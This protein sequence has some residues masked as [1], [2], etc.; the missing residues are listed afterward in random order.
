MKKTIVLLALFASLAYAPSVLACSPAPGYP[1]SASDNLAQKDVAFIGTVTSIMR[2]KSVNGDYH[3]TFAVN[4]SLKGSMDGTV[5]VTTRSSS[6]ACG[7]DDAY[8][9]FKTGAVWAMYAVGTESTYSTNS[10]SLNTPY[11]SVKTARAE[12]ETLGIR[13]EETTPTMCTMQYQPVCGKASNGTIKTFGNACTLAAEKAQFL[14]E[15]ECKVA[16]S[17]VPTKNLWIGMRGMDVT[18]LQNFLITKATGA[19]SELLKKVGATGYFGTL[20]KNALA[21]Y[22]AARGVTPAVGYFGPLTRA[23]ILLDTA[24]F[25][26]ATFKGKIS[27]VDTACFADGVCSVTIDGR[28]VVLAAG[29]RINVPPLG[30]LTGVDSIGDLEDEIGSEAEVYA[31]KVQDG[32]YTL[33]GSTSYYVKVI[34]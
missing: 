13:P 10:L 8:S 23:Q 19:A 2:D 9:S 15:G 21:E 26:T 22:Q 28:K 7:Y 20:T 27:A 6:A 14:Y 34:K 32:S 25:E 29:L 33:Y 18:W 24:P 17:T 30:S 12:L 16:V 1:L 3:I 11:P 31:A 4:E 5:T